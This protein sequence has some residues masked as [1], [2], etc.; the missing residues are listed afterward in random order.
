MSF[1]YEG[2]T[3]PT[4]AGESVLLALL[5]E[6][7]HPGGGGPLCFEGDCP[8]CL[9][10]VD[11][12][13]Y[14]R[15]CQTPA[16]VAVQVSPHGRDAPPL[17][18]LD[19]GARAI[20][21]DYRV[22]D[23]VVI[24]G[25]ESGLQA[26]AE[27]EAVGRS[28][29]CFDAAAGHDVVAIYPGPLL[30]V[31]TH[32]GMIEVECDEIVVATGAAEIHPVVP[33]SDLEGLWMPR[34]AQKALDAGLDLGRL[35]S[36]GNVPG[37][38]GAAV[39]PGELVRFVGDET[40]TAVIT[41]TADGEVETPCDNVV[42]GLGLHP[43]T[44]L[45]RMGNGMNVRVVG[46]AT[47]QAD[48]P[49]CPPEGIACPC[50]N[51]TFE[52]LDNLHDR[53]F[54]HME[55]L[56]RGSLAGTGTCQGSVCTPYLRSFLQD[57]GQELQ[58]PFTAR[59]VARQLTLSEMAAGS[60]LPKLARTALDDVHRSLGAQMDRMGGW[61]RPWTYGDTDA[62]YTAVRERVALGDVSTLGK[63]IV[64]GPDAEAT[65]QRIFPT[66]V[67]TIKP[68]RSRYVLMLD[69][70]GYVLDDG[71]IAREH[72]DTFFLTFTSGGASMSE[73][74]IRD[75]SASWGHDIRILNQTLS[76]GAI[77]IT[78]PKA[79][80]V[81]ARATDGELPPFLGHS[82]LTIAGVEC[83]VFR[84]SFTGEMSYELHHPA[85]DSVAL[86]TALMELG[87]DHDIR[88][89]GIEALF[90]L[91]LEKGHIIIGQ[92]TDY[93]ASPRRLQHEWAV[94]M[95]TGDFIGRTA[96]ERTNRIPLDKLLVGI[97]TDGDTLVDGAVM[98]S[99]DEFAGTV[100][101][102]TWSPTL[103]KGVALAWLEAV[104]GAFPETVQVDGV[105]ARVVPPH[106]YDPEGSRARA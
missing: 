36:V 29:E 98:W 42:I 79:A 81:L 84:L 69:E 19:A 25:G 88:P 73:M 6:G 53:G 17:P 4:S 35:V 103:G 56:K 49:V 86:W 15:S 50:S 63:M 105:E 52:Q 7:I 5:R 64:T 70:R 13:S 62:E 67:S 104:D 90:R 23:V 87:A 45:A 85:A 32:D 11:D 27:A 93:D 46:D 59:P 24:G 10:T 75:W 3:I 2:Q 91:R 58:A 95:A 60:H 47:L 41:A 28:V 78:G 8:N 94:N 26:C 61:W 89:H 76:L 101:S 34:A 80:E 30:L 31:R 68:G 74:W 97:E 66:N 21:V 37:D 43:R 39:A 106:F 14:V 71:M 33:G 82:M 20:A 9:C 48:I 40:V 44:G 22:A 72:D 55:L 100:S 12:I 1:E 51:V 77:N 57:R 92:D 65:L 102:S 38:L 96:T 83:K 54:T 16:E 99:G 18:P